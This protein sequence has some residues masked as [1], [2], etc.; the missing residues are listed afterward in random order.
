[1]Q[2]RKTVSTVNKSVPKVNRATTVNNLSTKNPQNN[3]M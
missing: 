2:S 3:Q 1:M